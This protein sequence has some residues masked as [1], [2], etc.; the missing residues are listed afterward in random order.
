V[1]FSSAAGST[2]PN[3]TLTVTAPARSRATAAVPSPAA[4]VLA[5]ESSSGRDGPVVSDARRDRAQPPERVV[6]AVAIGSSDT[7]PLVR[8]IGPAR[9]G[10]AVV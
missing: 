8:T 2:G 5:T 1:F 7:F 3:A 10:A 6:V 9:P 4:N